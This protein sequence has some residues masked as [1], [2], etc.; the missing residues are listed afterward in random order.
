MRISW[1][2][3][4]CSTWGTEEN[5]DWHRLLLNGY[6]PESR[7]LKWRPCTALRG[8]FLFCGR[9]PVRSRFF[10]RNWST[11]VLFCGALQ[12]PLFWTHW[13]RLPLVCK[14]RVDH[15]LACFITCE[16]Q[17]IHQIHLCAMTLLTFWWSAWQLSLFWSTN[18]FMYK[19]IQILGPQAWDW[20]CGTVP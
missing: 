2:R 17:W 1:G 20:V 12:I 4:F 18:L 9:Y 11:L 16:L 7:D 10:K 5:G 3:V 15:L 19:C 13:W 14:V 8:L 6:P